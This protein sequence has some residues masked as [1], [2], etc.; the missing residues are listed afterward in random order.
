[1]SDAKSATRSLELLLLGGTLLFYIAVTLLAS[2]PDLIW[3]EGRYL[4]FAENLTQGF[5]VTPEKPD[6]IN[7][8]GYPLVLS[9]L[10]M[11]K[12][13]LLGLRMLNAVFM[14]LAVWFSFRAVLPY[15]GKRWALGV[16]LV[17]ALHPS[18]VRTAP[19]LMTEALALC[20]IAGFAWA[21]TAALRSEKSNWGMILAAAFAFAWLTLTR[22]FFGNVIMA[23]IA[24]LMLLL[25]FWKSQRT[26]L[27]RALA[28]L[29]LA[30]A[31]CVPWLAY[32][33]SK[34]GETLCW[35][36]NGGE[37]LYWATSTHE[38]EN[39]H[40]FS[41]EDAQNKPELVANGHRDFYK[42]NYY[43]PVKEREAALKKKALENIRAN[44][45]GVLKNCLSNWG[46]LIFGFPRSYQAEELIMLVL[47]AVNGPLVLAV[48]TALW[49]GWRCRGTIPAEI[50]ILALMA[51]IYLGGTS[52]LPGLPRYTI[53]VWPW[54][55][56]GLATI[57]SRH[58]KVSL[59]P[60]LLPP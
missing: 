54:I 19:Y 30:F 53:V 41:E 5:Y 32:T 56:L 37:L 6:V 42:A 23:S 36:T 58:L 55:G 29:A 48:L 27:W 57:V 46:R 50:L 44:P 31:M 2:R 35:S 60:K 47:V 13:P 15:A 7:G 49:V 40:W 51:F 4:W 33:K 1:M 3:D 16:A 38:G 52:L 43:L 8:P 21:F 12:T 17:T 25:P 11:V 9:A 18:L 26:V 10:L 14:A 39:G 22:V 20:C 24:F 28:V 34:T 45:T 59:S